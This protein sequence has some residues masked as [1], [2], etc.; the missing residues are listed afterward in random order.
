MSGKLEMTTKCKVKDCNRPTDVRG[1]C[2][3]HYF[4]W[5]RHSPDL[6]GKIRPKQLQLTGRQFGRWTVLNRVIRSDKNSYWL[7][8]CSCPEHT[9]RVIRGQALLNNDSTSCGCYFRERALVINLKHGHTRNHKPSPTWRTWSC[10]IS[11]CFTESSDSF[12]W[13]GGIG[14]TVCK[15]WLGKTGFQHFVDDM[16][17]RPEGTT[18]G[19]FGDIGSY[20][21]SNCA[22]MSHA[23][24][25]AV[26]S[27]KYQRI[28]NQL[29]KAA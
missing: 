2:Q 6:N 4:R 28:K 24:Q 8:Q 1:M 9:R 5:R 23:Q 11:R 3:T 26:R 19:R 13:Y 10:M 27:V 20:K 12:K 25:G 18:L 15:R 21:K 14:V 7:C 16:G 22:W 29:R 17:E